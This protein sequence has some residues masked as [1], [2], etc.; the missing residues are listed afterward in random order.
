MVKIKGNL[1]D[2]FD[3]NVF[4]VIVHGCNCHHDMG[5]GIA[6]QIAKRYPSALIADLNTDYGDKSKLGA[7][8]IAYI[9]AHDNTPYIGPVGPEGETDGPVRAIVN[10]YTQYHPGA[11]ARLKAIR[12]ALRTVN[13]LAKFSAWDSVRVG[14]PAIGCGIGGL[15]MEHLEPVVDRECKDTDIVLVEFG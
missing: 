2:M 12:Y 11:D 10:A 6:A 1:L 3:D 14:I 15:K 8:G 4:N 9:N 7:V 13:A 5:G